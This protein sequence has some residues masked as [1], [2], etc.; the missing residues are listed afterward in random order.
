M[1]VI[2]AL[3]HLMVRGMTQRVNA[4]AKHLQMAAGLPGSR[5]RRRLGGAPILLLEPQ[6]DRR[7]GFCGRRHLVIARSRERGYAAIQDRRLDCFATLAMTRC[8]CCNEAGHDLNDVFKQ[9]TPSG[10]LFLN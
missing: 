7:S 5:D 1:D 10:V 8:R 6:R 9:I 3:P 4:I 2:P